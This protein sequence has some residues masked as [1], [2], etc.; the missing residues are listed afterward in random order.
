M[1]RHALALRE[2]IVYTGPHSESAA[3]TDLVVAD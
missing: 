3:R 2:H 1:N